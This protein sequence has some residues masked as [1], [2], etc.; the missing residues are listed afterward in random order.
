MGPK[1][2]FTFLLLCENFLNSKSFTFKGWVGR[3]VKSETFHFFIVH[4]RHR[5]FCVSGYDLVV[6]LASLLVNEFA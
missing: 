3:S 1:P 5:L 4:L 2:F 6:H